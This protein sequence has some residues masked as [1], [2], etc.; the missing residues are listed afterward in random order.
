MAVDWNEIK[1]EYIAGGTSYRKLCADHGVKMSELRSKAKSEKWVEL[2]TQA[3]HKTDTEIVNKVSKKNAKKAV[4]IDTVADKLLKKMVDGMETM[5]FDA[6]SLKQFTSALSD[7]AKIK[8]HKTKEDIRE[9]EA[10]I[11]A[12]KARALANKPIDDEDEQGGVILLS[13]VD[14]FAEGTDGS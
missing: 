12:L 8:G 4:K 14:E 11:D 1:A 6:Q 7:L 9:Q 13:D 10:R 2:Q 3:K 5:V